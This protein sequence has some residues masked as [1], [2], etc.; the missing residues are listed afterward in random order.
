M[1]NTGFT[2]TPSVGATLVTG[3]TLTSANDESPRDP[4]SYALE[5]SLDGTAFF[6]ISSGAVPA[7][8]SRFYKNYIFFPNTHMFKA[9]RLIFPT[10]VNAPTA[11]TCMQI[12]EVEFLGVV[13]DLPTDVTQPGDPIV[14]SS[15]NSPGSEG[16]ANAIDNGQSKYLNFD[17]L[18]TGFTVSPSVGLTIVNGLTLTSANDDPER[19]PSSYQLEGSYDGTTFMVISE[20]SVAAFP[21]RFYKNTI[22]FEN[23]VPYL[24]YRLIFPTVVNAPITANSMQISEVE[25]LGVL[26]PTDVTQPGDPIVA[27]SNNSPGSEGVANAIDNAQSKYLNFDI[28]NTGF[29]VT[30][31]VGDTIVSGL[32][33]TSAN[34]FPERDPASYTLE[35]SLDGTT[36][37]PISSGAV[38]AFPSRYFKNY[39]FFPDNATAFKSYRLIFPTV[40]NAPSAATCM[41]ISEVEFLGVVPGGGGNL[42]LTNTLVKRQPVDTPVLPGSQATF[43]VT[44]TGPWKVQWYRVSGGATNKIAGANTASYVTPAVTEETD[45]GALFYAVV[46]S[47]KEYQVTTE[48]MLSV[49]TP[50]ETVSLGFSFLGSGAN[51]APTSMLTDDIAGYQKQAYWNNISA[52]SGSL[53]MPLNSN[54]EQD[55]DITVTWA[56]SGEWGVG[57]RQENGDQRMLNGMDT[58]TSTTAPGESITFA[59]VPAGTH[60]VLLYTVQVP[61]EYFNMDF[62]LTTYDAFG[63]P[64]EVQQR[65]IRP[66]NSDE[67]NADS[68]WVV[69]TANT[70]ENRAVGNMMRFDNLQPEDGRI[71]I[72]FYSPGRAQTAGQP[73]RGPGL[74]GFQLLLNPPALP[75][76]PVITANPVSA[77]GVVGGQVSLKVEAT[78]SDL[79]F[80]WLKNGVPI[81]GATG[82]ELVLSAVQLADAGA[83]AVSI[84]NA[85]GTVLSRVAPVDILLSPFIT[86]GLILYYKMEVG[87]QALTVTN[88]VIGGPAAEVRTAAGLSTYVP[89]QILYPDGSG[90]GV[91]LNGTDEYVYVPDYAKLS[92][93]LSV[94]AWVSSTW[95]SFG[96][97]ANN[98][99]SAKAIGAH[100]QFLLEATNVANVMT[101]HGAIECGPNQPLAVAAIPTTDANVWHHVALTANGVSLSIY[102]DGAL[103]SSLDYSGTINP[104]T[105][106]WLAI[107]AN[108]TGNTDP[109][110]SSA[111]AGAFDDF[112]LWGRGLSDVE[113]K[114]IYD[115]GLNN[116]DL[117]QLPPVLL[118]QPTIK[119][120]RGADRMKLSWETT[121]NYVLQST[122]SLTAPDWKPVTGVAN[123][124]ITIN[125]SGAGAFY[126]LLRQ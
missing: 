33:F 78:G 58:S 80:Q 46:S 115:G 34:D 104:T 63:A 97:I 51:G 85:A 10:V 60:S 77:N 99:D 116:Q 35:G 17:I 122:P 119:I 50:S 56:T 29:T 64:K 27:T 9:Y 83:Y 55:Q 6:P 105:A 61:K 118:I 67:Y 109:I 107:G 98:W 42:V 111:W 31:G 120:E 126:R 40:V 96:P 121:E 101:L 72:E 123:N 41:Q 8:P 62:T 2:V 114:A 86:D 44:M 84:S 59:G 81:P 12:S 21:S 108:L 106:P 92:K 70:P 48:A 73:I 54:N 76:P 52:G 39:I 79:K 66:Q 91:M 19:D 90:Y 43:L 100:G 25:L 82:P 32:S 16:V 69:V 68:S 102:W 89:G 87:D 37:F 24:K 113:V 11:A 88:E 53:P 1:L 38:P 15:N 75:E 36:F 65:F 95:G 23:K 45:D 30:P 94:S 57:T 4:S 117:Q 125:Y 110:M 93:A 26:A 28:L 20:G 18:N 71:L 124:A 14:A 7:F 112:A 5:G 47:P 74:N 13:S 3:L 49:F 22:L 103:L